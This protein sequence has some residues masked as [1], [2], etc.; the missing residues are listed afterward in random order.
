[1]RPSIIG[2]GEDF[3]MRYGDKERE[4]VA[5][6]D[7]LNDIPVASSLGPSSEG[8]SPSLLVYA[9]IAPGEYNVELMKVSPL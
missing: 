2:R 6:F 9:D 3:Y 7:F 8:S 1:M 4:A 5:S